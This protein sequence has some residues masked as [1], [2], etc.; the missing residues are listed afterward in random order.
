M[1]SYRIEINV[2]AE[3]KKI[4][5]AINQNR[6]VPSLKQT[7]ILSLSTLY[8]FPELTIIIFGEIDPF[9]LLSSYGYMV[10]RP[11]IFDS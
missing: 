10:K 3:F 4:V 8:I 6:L 9:P 2:A 11:S 5:I 1:R 7:P